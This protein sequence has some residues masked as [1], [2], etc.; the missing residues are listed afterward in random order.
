VVGARFEKK[1][2][3]KRC[4]K[5]R[6]GGSALDVDNLKK[7]Q[8]QH[9]AKRLHRSRRILAEINQAEKHYKNHPAVESF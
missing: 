7:K 6:L 3:V 2:K 1:K 5:P 4:D 9:H 8:H